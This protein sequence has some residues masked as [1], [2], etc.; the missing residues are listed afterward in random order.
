[1]IRTLL[2]F[3]TLLLP[4]SLLAQRTTYEN[5]NAWFTWFGDLEI[6]PKWSIDFD[7]SERRSGPLDEQGQFLWRAALRRN[8]AANVRVSVGYAG[9]DTRPYGKLPIAFRAPEHRVFQQLQLTQ[10]AGRAQ[11]THRYRLEQRWAGRVAVVDG[12]TAVRNW[13]RTNR[14]RYMARATIPL[15]GRTLEPKEW[16]LNLTDEV[17]LNFGANVNQ[18]VFDQNR[19]Q[20][21]IG[22]R[23]SKDVRLELGFLEHLVLRPSGRQLERNHTIVTTLTTAFHR[24]GAKKG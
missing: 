22:R 11:F 12:D 1:M 7:A 8:V 21:N 17:M 2:L 20:L 3:G 15:Q 9:T 19:S 4:S 13:I 14:M 24:P 10:N 5:V 23:V 18:N 6:D 16:F